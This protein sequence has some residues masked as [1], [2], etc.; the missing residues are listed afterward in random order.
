MS[1]FLVSS[2]IPADYDA[3]GNKINEVDNKPQKEKE[4]G[5]EE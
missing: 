4:G 3:N 1:G 2:M 5:G